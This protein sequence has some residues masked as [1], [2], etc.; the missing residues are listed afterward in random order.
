T[1]P[2]GQAFPRRESR[3]HGPRP[4]PAAPGRRGRRP[5]S[6]GQSHMAGVSEAYRARAIGAPA[7]GIAFRTTEFMPRDAARRP[8]LP[9]GGSGAPGFHRYDAKPQATIGDARRHRVAGG[10]IAGG[11]HDAAVVALQDAV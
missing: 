10:D 1:T 2:A 3:R 11:A 5:W 7:A 8:I 4:R 9:V 6:C